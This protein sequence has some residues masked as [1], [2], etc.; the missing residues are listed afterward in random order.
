MKAGGKTIEV[1]RVMITDDG[2]K[3]LEK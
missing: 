3:E 2:R 1:V